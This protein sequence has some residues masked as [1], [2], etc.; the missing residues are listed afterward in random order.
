[1]T[2]GESFQ[3]WFP[4]T[5]SPLICSAPMREI[6]GAALAVATSAGGGLG[7]IAAGNDVS[8][9]EVKFQEAQRLVS[10]EK[11]RESSSSQTNALTR[12]TSAGLPVGVGFLNWGA[13]IDVAVPLIVKYRPVAVWLFAPRDNALDLRTWVSRIRNEVEGRTT[14]WVQVGDIEDAVDAVTHLEPDVLVLQGADGGGHGLATSASILSLV[15][16]MV[17]ILTASKISGD[18]KSHIPKIVAA[19][20]LV[21]GRGVAA[22]LTLGA[23]GVAMGTRFLAS[24]ES[25]APKEYLK[26]V[27]EAKNGGKT[28]I[29]S[30]IFD[31]ARG[32]GLWPKKYGPRGVINQTYRDLS[33]GRAT[34]PEITERYQADLHGSGVKYGPEGRIATLVGTSVGLV[35]EALP[36][37]EIV[38]R[39]RKQTEMI[40]SP[41]FAARL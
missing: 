8:N 35:R 34:V 9:L 30:S 36:A 18:P 31:T 37:A 39:V 23:E 4:W 26:A 16:E 28:T 19:G 11:A 3:Q 22:A 1:M 12:H 15:P 38:R 40:L 14:I 2:S 41:A 29:R 13:D 20:G 25:E 17:D 27:V 10:L 5:V 7:F 33:S 24:F 32:I 21:D 6:S